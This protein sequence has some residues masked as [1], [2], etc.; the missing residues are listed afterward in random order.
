MKCVISSVMYVRQNCV[1]ISKDLKF[2]KWSVLLSTAWQQFFLKWFEDLNSKP[3][4]PGLQ[5]N[6]GQPP[7]PLAPSAAPDINPIKCFLQPL[8]LL[9]NAKEYPQFHGTF[10]H[11]GPE[12]PHSFSRVFYKVF[13]SS[14]LPTSISSIINMTKWIS[15]VVIIKNN[16]MRAQC[17]MAAD[18]SL[19]SLVYNLLPV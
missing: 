15:Y 19:L 2:G 14:H 1:T 6:S 12:G 13:S 3:M 11:E 18:S 7:S 4:L 9:S 16:A 10:R 8:G 5:L 17:A